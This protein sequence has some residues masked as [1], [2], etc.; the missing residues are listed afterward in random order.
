MKTTVEEQVA[1]Y[2]RAVTATMERERSPEI[3]VLHEYAGPHGAPRRGRSVWAIAA[4][5]LFGLLVAAGAAVLGG[6]T[7]TDLAAPA[8]DEDAIARGLLDDAVAL[9]EQG[10]ADQLCAQL[11]ASETFCHQIYDDLDPV[12]VPSTPPEVVGAR[13]IDGEQVGPAYV[14]TV[15]GLDGAGQPYVTDFSVM[16][17]GGETYAVQNPIYWSDIELIVPTPSDDGTAGGEVSAEDV[18]SP[19]DAPAGCPRAS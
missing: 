13:T 7:D 14:L 1:R 18:E 10:D 11:A 5:V 17:M 12:L 16:P 9:V 2:S 15:C 8:E 6:G 4:L 19:A 3:R